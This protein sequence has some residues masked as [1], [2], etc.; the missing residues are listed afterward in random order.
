[1]IKFYKTLAVIG[2]ATLISSCQSTVFGVDKEVWET[3]NEEQRTEAIRSYNKIKE[4]EAQER[5]EKERQKRKHAEYRSAEAEKNAKVIRVILK[6]GEIK[7]NKQTHK[8]RYEEA[9]ITHGTI[10]HFD[11]E[12]YDETKK[13]LRSCKVTYK[14]GILKIGSTNSSLEKAI[15][16]EYNETWKDGVNYKHLDFPFH[17]DYDGWISLY[18]TTKKDKDDHNSFK[19]GNGTSLQFKI[20][21]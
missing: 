6:G 15:E 5:I 1:M 7:K 19:L 2:L 9:V 20:G 14:N 8:L 11:F 16:L 3:L 21:K 13:S 17:A 10:S 12:S 18:I 4:V